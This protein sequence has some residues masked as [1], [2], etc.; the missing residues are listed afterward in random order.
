MGFSGNPETGKSPIMFLSKLDPDV[1]T[2]VKHYKKSTITLQV[3]ALC[4]ISIIE[5]NK[6]MGYETYSKWLY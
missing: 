5:N 3:V 6:N 2:M 1:Q 4:W